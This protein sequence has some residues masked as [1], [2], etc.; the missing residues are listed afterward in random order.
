MKKIRRSKGD[1]NKQELREYNGTRGSE[2]KKKCY[3]MPVTYKL[4]FSQTLK[5][6]GL[7]PLEILGI[8][9]DSLLFN[10]ESRHPS[11][12]IDEIF[13][14]LDLDIPTSII[15]YPESAQSHVMHKEEISILI[16]IK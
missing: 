7:Q 13:D 16:G 14:T 4:N 6:I 1:Y 2:E 8:L 9:K 10:E 12:N 3:N 15:Q 5:I 11:L